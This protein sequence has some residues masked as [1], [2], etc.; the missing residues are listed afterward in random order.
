[1]SCLKI[2]P[3]PFGLQINANSLFCGSKI[4]YFL[5][6]RFRVFHSHLDILAFDCSIFFLSMATVRVNY[7]ILSRTTPLLPKQGPCRT[8]SS[9][10]FNKK[11]AVLPKRSY[12]CRAIYNP[13]VQVK[14][15]GK[16]ETLDYRVFFLDNSGKKVIYYFR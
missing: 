13:Q 7:C 3:D 15:E 6:S 10:F 2:E 5:Q 1:M 8:I 4:K 11:R 16:S 14:E 12:I 9:I